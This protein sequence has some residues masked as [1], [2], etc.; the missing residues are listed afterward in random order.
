MKAEVCSRKLNINLKC[1]RDWTMLTT[2]KLFLSNCKSS[3][4]PV[5]PKEHIRKMIY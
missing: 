3:I 2:F 5:T 4:P 1:K